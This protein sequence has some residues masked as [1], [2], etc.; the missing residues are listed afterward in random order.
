MHG[1]SSSDCIGT[2]VKL[3]SDQFV[4]P[5]MGESSAPGIARRHAIQRPY[6]LRYVLLVNIFEAKNATR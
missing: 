6:K 3:G 2:R 5:G 1:A 4:A